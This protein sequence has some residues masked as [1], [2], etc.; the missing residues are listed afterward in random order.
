MKSALFV[1]FDNVYSSLRRLDPSAADRFAQQPDTWIEWLTDTLQPPPH[2]PV[3]EGRRL[4]VRRCYLNPHAYQRFRPAFNRT[5]FEIIDCPPMTSDGKTSTDIHMVLD[6]I[7]LLQHEVHYDEFIVFSADADFT[8]VLRKLRRWDRRTTVLAVGFPSAAYRASADLLIDQDEFVR[9]GLG[10]REEVVVPDP[11]P[12]PPRPPAVDITGAATGY[13]RQLVQAA[14]RPVPLSTL[15]SKLVQE[16]NG[17]D[18]VNWAG[19][20]S[21]R[22]L[23]D[24]LAPQLMPLVADWE[25]GT[26]RD[27]GRHTDT[28]QART[29]QDYGARQL[30]QIGQGVS[31]LIFAELRK[32]GRPVSCARLAQLIVGRYPDMAA[33]WAGQGSFRRFMDSMDFPDLT[34]EW[35][36]GGG[37]VSDPLAKAPT[38]AAVLPGWEQHP[39]LLSTIQQVHLATGM[40]IMSPPEM[41]GLLRALAA[42]TTHQDFVLSE[43]GKRVRDRCRDE[44][45]GVSR[46]DVSYV[47]KGIVL[48]GHDFGQNSNDA[49]SLAARFIKNMKVICAREQLEVDPLMDRALLEWCTGES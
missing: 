21:F 2:A 3:A 48:A 44:G 1:D 23:M 7:D 31:D 11:L 33:D 13:I 39:H 9:S 18:A 47:L 38:R 25:S 34:I 16:V 24:A 14:P 10:L 28:V 8:P 30:E 6:I 19:L 15:A 35:D 43:T 32:T 42:E 4:L 17:L 45:L 27:P 49:A 40:P 12:L 36:R 46:A 26:I 29:P 41:Q 37:L 22:K 5:G 20:G